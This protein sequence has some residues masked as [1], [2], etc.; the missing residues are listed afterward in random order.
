MSAS[1]TFPLALRWL[2]LAP[3][4][5][6]FVSYAL[7]KGAALGGFIIAC[8]AECLFVPIAIFYLMRGGYFTLGNVLI[9]LIASV[10]A[11]LLV[12][13]VLTL[14]FGHFHI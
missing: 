5:L 2:L 14:K 7:P 9:T 6:F 4:A 12:I 3:L 10:P 8:I 13:L 11:G 1:K